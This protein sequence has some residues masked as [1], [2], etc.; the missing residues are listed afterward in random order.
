MR[1]Y[2]FICRSLKNMITLRNPSYLLK[3]FLIRR[4]TDN[5]T[6]HSG[7]SFSQGDSVTGFYSIFLLLNWQMFLAVKVDHHAWRGFYE[8]TLTSHR[9]LTD[10]NSPVGPHFMALLIY[11]KQISALA[12]NCTLT[13]SSVFNGLA[14]IFF[15]RARLLPH[16]KL[17][18]SL[19]VWL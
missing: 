17:K 7:V 10:G 3:Q 1:E 14:G 6:L 11:R 9:A 16:L 19:L 4:P 2:V 15:S 12:G 13:T 5:V 18:S 8:P